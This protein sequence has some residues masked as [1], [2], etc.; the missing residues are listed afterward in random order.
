[1]W[2]IS[3]SLSQFLS[4]LPWLPVSTATF[5]WRELGLSQKPSVFLFLNYESAVIHDT[6][7]EA[8][9]SSG[10]ELMNFHMIFGDSTMDFHMASNVS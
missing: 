9:Q 10:A 7:K 4:D 6:V 2:I 8:L 1:L 3:A 5:S